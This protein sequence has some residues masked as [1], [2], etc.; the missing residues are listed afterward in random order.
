MQAHLRQLLWPQA[1]QAVHQQG[2]K[3]TS[4]RRVRVS[5]GG[6]ACTPL[7]QTKQPATSDATSSCLTP[8]TAQHSALAAVKHRP[9]CLCDGVEDPHAPAKLTVP[10]AS[11]CATSQVWEVQP[12]TR[13]PTLRCCGA[14]AGKA[15][16]MLSSNCRRGCPSG[17]AVNWAASWA[18]R[19]VGK[20]CGATAAALAR[21]SVRAGSAPPRACRLW[22]QPGAP[23]AGDAARRARAAPAVGLKDC[24]RRDDVWRHPRHSAAGS[25]NPAS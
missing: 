8:S 25:P 24:A 10:S 6:A 11:R 17:S 21:H 9:P 16:A 22:A 2:R 7:R 12:C 20:T 19:G 14:I 13:V 1:S 15:A 5:C 18:R 4:H 3:S 23:H